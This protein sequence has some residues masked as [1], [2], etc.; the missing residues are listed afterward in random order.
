MRAVFLMCIIEE[1]MRRILTIICV[2]TL[3]LAGC[4]THKEAEFTEPVIITNSDS[5]HTQ[6][7]EKVR[8]DT[9]TIEIAVPVE[10]EKQTVRDSVSRL[11][12]SLAISEARINKDGMLFHFLKNKEQK[13]KAEVPVMA[14][15]TETSQMAEKVKEVP[16]PYPQKVFV[17]RNFTK[18]EQIKLKFFWYLFG[19]CVC[20]VIFAFRK[21]LWTVIRKF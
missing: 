10:S 9:V 16:V 1:I 2:I 8:I 17:E 6:Y 14:K 13:L 5:I 11:E 7:I 19:L 21:P 18:W 3:A 15:D 12:T 4:R 20:S